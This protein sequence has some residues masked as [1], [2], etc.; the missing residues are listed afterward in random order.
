M[1]PHGGGSAAR[2]GPERGALP[3]CPLPGRHSRPSSP[4]PPAPH[5]SPQGTSCLGIRALHS[6]TD[7]IVTELFDF[8]LILPKIAA[9]EPYFA[10]ST[11]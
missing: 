5:L 8:C 1:G 4:P 11:N 3:C 2:A 9:I 7:P 6:S 10:R